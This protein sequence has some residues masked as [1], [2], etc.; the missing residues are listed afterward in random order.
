MPP[1][2]G[3]LGMGADGNAVMSRIM[4]CWGVSPPASA[5]ASSRW[6]AALLGALVRVE[7]TPGMGRGALLR[8]KFGCCPSLC[9]SHRA[10]TV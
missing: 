5:P 2:P 7:R 6:A 4:R 8:L 9:M 10:T 3:M 1:M